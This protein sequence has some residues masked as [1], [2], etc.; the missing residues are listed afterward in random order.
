MGATPAESAA[1]RGAEPRPTL[2]RLVEHLDPGVIRPMASDQSDILDVAAGAPTL[3]A[4]AE[5]LT[6]QPGAVVL[7]VGTDPITAAARDLLGQAA[8]QRAAAIVFQTS[9]APDDEGLRRLVDA[10]DREGVVPLMVGVDV[11]WGQL[12]RLLRAAASRTGMALE[13]GWTSVPAGDL[14]A[15]ANAI[16]AMV[17]GPVTIEDPQSQVL[18][19]SSLDEPIDEFR[20]GAILRRGVSKRWIQRLSDAGIFKALW[21]EEKVVK[22]E[23]FAERGMKPRLAIA[24]RAG[25][26]VLGSIWVAEGRQPFA[27]GAEDALLDAARLAALHLL[28]YRA[29]ADIE[30]QARAAHF[31]SLLEGRGPVEVAAERLG[32]ELHV[33]VVV[34]A[35]EVIGHSPSVDRVPAVL[36]G[37]WE[38]FRRPAVC[39]ALD[40]AIYAIIP[41]RPSLERDRLLSMTADVI[42]HVADAVGVR[43]RAGVGAPT[44]SLH[45]VPTSRREADRALQATAPAGRGADPSIDDPVVVGIESVR[46]RVLLD[47][48]RRLMQ[49]EENLR[50]GRVSALAAHDEA[51][52]SVF[53]E[54]L[55]C[56]LDAFGDMNAAADLM[57]VHPKT[58][59]YRFKR[60]VAMS[61]IDLTDPTERLVAHLQLRAVTPLASV[62]A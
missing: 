53:S 30:R 9:R 12:Y 44:E 40:Q 19:Y 59:R 61:K 3:H 38:S 11:A 42:G 57:N 56:F 55:L 33:P 48:V 8:A 20:R 50:S 25:R 21:A 37:Y 6:V 18:A 31:E 13:A 23:E 43:L 60:A 24:V 58:F 47:D 14:F 62:D 52:G 51:H 54:T 39:A 27:P 32:L 49:S 35:F 15:L 17:G 28:S 41:L 36:N 1:P 7:A 46:T 45:G 5:R 22:V 2:R 29:S 16:A 10:A 34:A 26:E 4:P